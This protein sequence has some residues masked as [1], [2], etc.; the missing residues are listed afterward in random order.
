MSILD[1]VDLRRFE[2][3][4]IASVRQVSQMFCREAQAATVVSLTADRYR[5]HDWRE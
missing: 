4:V 1:E 2:G 3:R 5:V